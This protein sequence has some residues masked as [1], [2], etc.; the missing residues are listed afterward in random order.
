MKELK[1]I[2]LLK[3]LSEDL[4]Q[5]IGLDSR[6]ELEESEDDVYMINISS[7]S[8]TGLLIGYK[9][10]NI[11]AIQ[12]VLSL[13][14]R[15]VTGRWVRVLVNVGDYRQKQED[16]LRDLAD[17]T[18]LRVKETGEPQ[19]LYNLTASQRRIIHMYLSENKEV[20]SVSEGEG[21]NRYLVISVK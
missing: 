7:D 6:V 12:T 21:D 13:M 5:K 11:N 1:D 14:F 10:E 9:G 16:K 20:E 15:G 17:Q 18:V 2:D 3:K 8:E 19:P 4:L